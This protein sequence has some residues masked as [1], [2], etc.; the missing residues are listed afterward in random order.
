MIVGTNHFISLYH[1]YKYYR[2]QQ[3]DSIQVNEKIKNGEI[4][5]GRPDTRPDERIVLLDEN[6]RY[7]IND[8]KI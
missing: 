6:C 1:A 3:V 7:G 4:K 5:I 8:R 2:T